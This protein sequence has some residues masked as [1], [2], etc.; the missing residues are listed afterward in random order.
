MRR[1]RALTKPSPYPAFPQQLAISPLPEDAPLVSNRDTAKWRSQADSVPQMAICLFKTQRQT[2]G[3]MTLVGFSCARTTVSVVIGGRSRLR[4]LSGSGV[5]PVETRSLIFR[6][7]GR[8]V[9][10]GRAGCR[11]ESIQCWTFANYSS[12]FN[13]WLCKI[14]SIVEAFPAP[15]SLHFVRL[16]VDPKIRKMVN[17]LR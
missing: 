13:R 2:A 17:S 16:N 6:S 1:R 5:V 8:A 14:I 4:M 12:S 15:P 11:S 9:L 3:V 10:R 7:F